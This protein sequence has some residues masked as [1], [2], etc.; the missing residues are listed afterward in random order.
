MPLIRL[1]AY[2]IEKDKLRRKLAERLEQIGFTR[3]Q[4]SVF[5]GSVRQQVLQQFLSQ[6]E[7]QLAEDDRLLVVPL[8]D[9]QVDA[10]YRIGLNENLDLMLNRLRTW[11]V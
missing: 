5:L 2:D 11:V 1:I 6:Y 7:P 3:V 4:K 9:T 8:T 10:M